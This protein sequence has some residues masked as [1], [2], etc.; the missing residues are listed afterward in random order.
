MKLSEHLRNARV[1]RPDEWT[2]DEFIRAA[3]KLEKTANDKSVEY[4]KLVNDFN[5]KINRIP[6]AIE[7]VNP[8]VDFSSGRY[9]EIFIDIEGCCATLAEDFYLFAEEAEK[10][11]LT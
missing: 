11:L 5:N 8:K 4:G 10:L 1:D 9:R 2:M 7:E 3:E 6:I